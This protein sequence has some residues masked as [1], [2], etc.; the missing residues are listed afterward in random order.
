MHIAAI[1]GVKDEAELIGPCIERLQALGVETIVVLDDYSTDGTAEIV[2]AYEA[3]AAGKLWRVEFAPDLKSNLSRTGHVL[4]PLLEKHKPDWVLFT[5]ADEFW[6]TSTGDLATLLQAQT[7]DG[8]V[9]ER[10]NVPLMSPPFSLVT[11]FDQKALLD[12][13]LIVVRDYLTRAVLEQAPDKR[14][15]TNA[16]QPKMICRADRLDAFDPGA[17]TA[18]SVDGARMV[19]TKLAD[20]V[21]VHVPLTT[22]TRFARKVRNTRLFFERWIKEYPGESAWH[23]KRWVE[24][25]DGGVLLAEF[26]RQLMLQDELHVLRQSGVV[27]SAGEYLAE[28]GGNA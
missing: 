23:W 5:D 13:P 7:G 9:V 24:L 22:P 8:F 28:R 16:I 6:V 2:A 26:E 1:I 14:W 17:H 3:R 21:I 15:V 25:D 4:G 12:A 11:G 18:R 19:T 10:F 27:K 20:A